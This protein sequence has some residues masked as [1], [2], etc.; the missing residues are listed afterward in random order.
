MKV[1]NG[2]NLWQ[3]FD[4]DE[5]PSLEQTLGAL[6]SDMGL[7]LEVKMTTPSAV[8]HTDPSEVDRVV[9]AILKTI[10]RFRQS[11]A[12][13]GHGAL[14]LSSFDPDVCAAL[15]KGQSEIPVMFITTG[16]AEPHANPVRMSIDA[17]IDFA[18]SHGMD[19]IVVDSSVLRKNISS[20]SDAQEKGLKVMSYGLENNDVEWVHYQS[21]VGVHGAIVDDVVNILPALIENRV[22]M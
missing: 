2:S 19:G 18:H 4:D 8:A 22:K 6:P 5:L 12:R 9:N 21:E 3:C 14:V 11:R 1:S 13:F 20:V 17:A 10:T 15:R 16:G 7:N